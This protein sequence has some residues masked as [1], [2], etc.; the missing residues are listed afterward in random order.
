MSLE[1][2]SPWLGWGMLVCAVMTVIWLFRVKSK[3]P[4]AWIMA[5]AF[6]AMGGLMYAIQQAAA[7]WV[8]WSLAG[9]LVLL[10][11]L[12]AAVRAANRQETA[13]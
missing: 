10:L 11:V 1:Q 13:E 2:I 5:A 6:V 4:T 8:I 9:L 3:G 12:D 7:G